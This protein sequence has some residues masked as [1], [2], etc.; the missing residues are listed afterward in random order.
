MTGYGAALAF[1][2]IGVLFVGR[3]AESSLDYSLEHDATN[4]LAR[5]VA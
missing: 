2:L 5:N 3:V 4:A 1:P